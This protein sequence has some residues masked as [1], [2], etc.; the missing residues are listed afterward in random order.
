MAFFGKG[1]MSREGAKGAGQEIYSESAPNGYN[2]QE[3]LRLQQL[4]TQIE[5]QIPY[6]AQEGIEAELAKRMAAWHAMGIDVADIRDP[7][8]GFIEMT[9]AFMVQT[10]LARPATKKYLIMIDSDI[11]PPWEAP[12][13]LAGHDLPVVSGVAC[14]WK[15]DVG[16]F[17]CFALKDANGVER[18]PTLK[19]NA[20]MPAGGVVKIGHAGAGIICIRRDVLETIQERE[21]P[22]FLPEDVR[23]ES[24]RQGTVKKSEDIVFSEQVHRAGFAMHVDFAVRCVHYKKIPLAWPNTNVDPEMKPEEFMANV[25]D[26]KAF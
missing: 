3:M 5:V 21:E 4:A 18:F 10:F 19:P 25:F 26:Y 16:L 17:C 23:R 11:V 20:K 6:R 12:L 1:M 8:G 7:F 24:V 14:G 2:E 15:P 13:A 22:F 9:R